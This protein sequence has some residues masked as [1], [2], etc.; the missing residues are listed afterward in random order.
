MATSHTGLPVSV[1]VDAI[2][3][4]AADLRAV[5]PAAWV[6]TKRGLAVGGELVLKDAQANAGF[7]TGFLVLGWCRSRRLG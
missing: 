5:S 1:D 6:A 7:W 3:V 4:L 2:R